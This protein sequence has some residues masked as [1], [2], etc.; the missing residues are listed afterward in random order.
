MLAKRK[1]YMAKVHEKLGHWNWATK[2]VPGYTCTRVPGSA[3]KLVLAR[4]QYWVS[5]YSA[6]V[7]LLL[8]SG[9]RVHVHPGM[10]TLLRVGTRYPGIHNNQDPR[11]VLG[12]VVRSTGTV[13]DY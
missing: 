9:G 4:S 7:L 13:G 11:L 6:L 5:Y 2:L 10:S 1:C 12:V 3:H 8:V